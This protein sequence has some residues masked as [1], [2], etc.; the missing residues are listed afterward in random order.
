MNVVLILQ[1]C[2]IFKVQ[3]ANIKKIATVYFGGALIEKVILFHSL[4]LVIRTPEAFAHHVLI[5]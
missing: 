3:V 5:I 1:R 2:R 4:K